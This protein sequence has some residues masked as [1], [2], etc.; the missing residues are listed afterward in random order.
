[1]AMLQAEAFA[2]H[3]LLFLSAVRIPSDTASGI[4]V[5]AVGFLSNIAGCRQFDSLN[6]DR[7]MVWRPAAT[8]WGP[9]RVVAMNGGCFRMLSPRWTSRHRGRF[10]RPWCSTRSCLAYGLHWE[11]SQWTRPWRRPCWCGWG[12]RSW[13]RRCRL[14][15]W[16][17]PSSHGGMGWMFGTGGRAAHVGGMLNGLTSLVRTQRQECEG[18]GS[19]EGVG[20]DNGPHNCFTAVFGSSK[21]RERAAGDV[22][23]G[24]K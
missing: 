8:R 12:R 5:S 17:K 4:R 20:D 10:Q 15:S 21:V 23:R 2:D 16:W 6:G 18:R 14:R 3:I 11:L 19:R 9:A 24:R 22:R 1:M 7:R 13:M